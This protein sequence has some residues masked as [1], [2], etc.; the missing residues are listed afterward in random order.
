MDFFRGTKNGFVWFCSIGV[1]NLE[2]KKNEVFIKK[3]KQCP[4]IIDQRIKK[5]QNS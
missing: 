4:Q 1:D 5:C 3:F 2:G